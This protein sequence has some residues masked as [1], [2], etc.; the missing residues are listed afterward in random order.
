M[1]ALTGLVPGSYAATYKGQSIGE[2]EGVKRLQIMPHGREVRADKYGESI[3]DVIDRG[4]DVYV[5]MILKEWN[6]NVEAVIWPFGTTFGTPL[7]V[8]GRLWSALAGALV[9][10]PLTGTPADTVGPGET[11]A[12]TF[13]LAIVA[14]NTLID[15]PLGSDQR[16]VPITFLC[17]PSSAG[18]A[19]VES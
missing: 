9:L 12:I 1:A 3:V 16:D 7:V 11:T 13:A 5:Q 8:S 15:I 6:A 2:T 14:P 4:Q 17:L 18:I 19:L 10:T